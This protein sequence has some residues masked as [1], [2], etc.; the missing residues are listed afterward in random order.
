MWA[1]RQKSPQNGCHRADF[2]LQKL[3]GRRHVW[4]GAVGQSPTAPADRYKQGYLAYE[5]AQ[6]LSRATH[7]LDHTDTETS[8]LT[9]YHDGG[10]SRRCAWHKHPS[11]GRADEIC[12]RGLA[13]I[14][15]SELLHPSH[16]WN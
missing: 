11:H 9:R 13:P 16:V 1:S 5:N 14:Y 12:A 10:G 7:M 15:C 2:G 8:R 6:D 3:E 4:S